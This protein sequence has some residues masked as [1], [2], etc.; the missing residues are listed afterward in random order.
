MTHIIAW[1]SIVGAGPR[2]CNTIAR[3]Q[4]AKKNLSTVW[5]SVE[6]SFPLFFDSRVTI[7]NLVITVHKIPCVNFKITAFSQEE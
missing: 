6:K 7:L 4:K 1:K 5:I 2:S 3:S